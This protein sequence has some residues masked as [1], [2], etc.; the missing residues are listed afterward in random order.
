LKLWSKEDREENTVSSLISG[1]PAGAED[2]HWAQMCKPELRWEERVSCCTKIH[3]LLS[4]PTVMHSRATASQLSST[5]R[6]QEHRSRQRPSGL[7][8]CCQQQPGKLQFW[9]CKYCWCCPKGDKKKNA[10]EDLAN[11]LIPSSFME[12]YLYSAVPW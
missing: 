4:F 8:W 12:V 10:Q 2:K 9:S 1:T 6:E 7:S 11:V 5:A 3:T